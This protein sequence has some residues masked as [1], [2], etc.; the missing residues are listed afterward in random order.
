MYSELDNS[1]YSS[2]NFI[3]ISLGSREASIPYVVRYFRVGLEDLLMIGN[4]W[5]EYQ[6]N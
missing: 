5:V 3:N 1:G 4:K 6:D 2:E